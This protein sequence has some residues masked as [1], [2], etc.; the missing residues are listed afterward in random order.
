MIYA[1]LDEND[2]IRLLN[3]GDK[4]AF[5]EIYKRYWKKLYQVAER[6]VR[7]EIAEEIIQDIF[8]S[9]WNNRKTTINNLKYYLFSSVKYGILNHFKKQITEYNFSEEA[10]YESSKFDNSTEYSLFLE[11]LLKSIEAALLHLPPKTQQ[12][13][14]LSRFELLSTKEIAVQLNLSEKAIEYHLTQA[15][16]TL[17]IYLKKHYFLCFYG[18]VFLKEYF[19]IE[20]L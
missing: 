16:K 5:Q 19:F 13:F 3:E 17:R 8:I 10:L 12:I 9:L 7:K 1:S 15:L 20:L 2:L 6:K 18:I 4:N 14:R 11:D